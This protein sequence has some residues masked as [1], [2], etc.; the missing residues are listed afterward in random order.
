MFD[1][2]IESQVKKKVVKATKKVLVVLTKMKVMVSV[3]SVMKEKKV[4]MMVV[5]DEKVAVTGE[6]LTL[7]LQ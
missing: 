2:T 6:S 5:E 3:A 7:E 4:A 1:F